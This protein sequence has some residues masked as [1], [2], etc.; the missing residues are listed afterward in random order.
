MARRAAQELFTPA[1]SQAG[2]FN[3]LYFSDDVSAVA[4]AYAGGQ[5]SARDYCRLEAVRHAR[6][7]G[8]NDVDTRLLCRG[9][10]RWSRKNNVPEKDRQ[11]IVYA[12][13][14]SAAETGQPLDAWKH[15][16]TLLEL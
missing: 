2:T 14:S 13:L 1:V 4:K 6:Q 10:D 15:V 7:A 11:D 12:V 9:I 16:K 3:R 8:Q 5:L